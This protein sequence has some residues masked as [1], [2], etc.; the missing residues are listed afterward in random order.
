MQKRIGL[1]GEMDLH[2]LSSI[3]E[4]DM[5]LNPSVLREALCI[6]EGTSERGAVQGK[7]RPYSLE[8]MGN[9]PQNQG[10]DGKD[11]TAYL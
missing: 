6:N 2:D 10:S 8:G 11:I 9:D 7:G 4:N 5:N 1:D 3:N